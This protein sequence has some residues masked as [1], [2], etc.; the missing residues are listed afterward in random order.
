M[1]KLHQRNGRTYLLEIW[2]SRLCRDVHWC[3]AVSRDDG[4]PCGRG[5]GKILEAAMLGD[6]CLQHI[7]EAL[8]RRTVDIG[9]GLAL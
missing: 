7:V 4:R 5:G 9:A 2:Y 6:H 8:S 3:V 1:M